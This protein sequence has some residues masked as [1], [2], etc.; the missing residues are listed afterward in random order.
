MDE[1]DWNPSEN[2]ITGKVEEEKGECAITYGSDVELGRN[3]DH[4]I[5]LPLTAMCSLTS[6]H[7]GIIPSTT[8]ISATSGSSHSKGSVDKRSRS[9]SLCDE[10][11]GGEGEDGGQGEVTGDAGGDDGGGGGDS[12]CDGSESAGGES[13]A[14][15]ESCKS[16]C[17]LWCERWTKIPQL[18][19]TEMCS[20]L[21]IDGQGTCTMCTSNI[22]TKHTCPMHR[23]LVPTTPTISPRHSLEIH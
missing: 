7:N 13:G 2:Q 19:M 9:Q 5:A 1:N 18:R 20:H 22:S 11:G 8:I 23:E 4:L 6:K 16:K 14:D 3:R 21:V 10:Y 15:R 12:A 17:R